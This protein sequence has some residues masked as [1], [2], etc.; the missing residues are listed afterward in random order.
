MAGYVQV[1]SSL[2]V[3]TLLDGVNDSQDDEGKARAIAASLHAR[4]GRTILLRDISL[5]P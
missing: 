2:A 5:K 1:S 3:R 4:A